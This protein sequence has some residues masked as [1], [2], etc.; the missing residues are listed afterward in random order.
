MRDSVHFNVKNHQ[1]MRLLLSIILFIF[2]STANATPQKCPIL[3]EPLHWAADYCMYLAGTDDFAHPK[4]VACF[5][6]QKEP[7]PSKACAAKIEY[8]KS[9]CEVVVKNESYQGSLIKCVHDKDF[10]G[11]TVSNSG[12]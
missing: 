2:V 6:K 11:P 8:K 10:S 3:G 7:S 12:L 9:M 5:Q 1:N 4:V